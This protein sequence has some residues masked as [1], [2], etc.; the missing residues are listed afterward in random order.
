MY[1]ARLA[2]L[3][4]LYSSI[5][6]AGLMKT[7]SARDAE[8]VD[9]L[10]RTIDFNFDPLHGEI[11]PSVHKLIEIGDPV[12]PRMLDL[13]LLD[14]ENY[15]HF[16]RLHAETVI[17]RIYLAKF[18]WNNPGPGWTNPTDEERFKVFWK[19]MP[20]LDHDAPLKERERA[21]KAWR[22]WHAN[23]KT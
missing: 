22:E 17:Y 12:I 10:V 19:S 6:C 18:G 20:T 7:H 21:V 5:G 16:T 2:T 11:T 1:V 8:S 3:L 4:I 13:M 15:H 14:G 23:R 9:D